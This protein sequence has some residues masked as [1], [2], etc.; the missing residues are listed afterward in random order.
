MSFR[1]WPKNATTSAVLDG[2]LRQASHVVAAAQGDELC[3]LDLKGGR[4]YTLNDVGGRVWTLLD[5]SITRAD[6]VDALRRTYDVRL[7]GHDDPV[8]GDVTRLLAELY[9]EGL[10]IVD[11]P[12]AHNL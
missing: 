6:I 12:A 7:D 4:F 10:V 9:E 5:G 3:L 2:R 11:A 1:F 8:E